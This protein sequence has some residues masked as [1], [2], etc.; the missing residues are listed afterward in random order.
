VVKIVPQ[1][2]S[3]RGALRPLHRT[4][5]PGITFLTPFIETIGRV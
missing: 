4:L 2:A 3:S 1:G 5:K